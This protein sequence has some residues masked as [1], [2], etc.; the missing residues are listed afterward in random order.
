MTICPESGQIVARQ[1]LFNPVA[2]QP[3]RLISAK[4]RRIARIESRRPAQSGSCQQATV[5]SVISAVAQD[6]VPKAVYS[7]R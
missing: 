5:V 1:T 6:E 7:R 3:I 4:N 2:G